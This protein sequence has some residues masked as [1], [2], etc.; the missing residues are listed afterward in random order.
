MEGEINS[1]IKVWFS[2]FISLGY[3]YAISKVVSKG[4]T[5]LICVLSIICLFIFLPVNLHSIHLGGITA[6]FIC[7]LANFKLLL[8]AFGKGPLCSGSSISLGR[9][10]AVGCSP[11][12]QNIPSKSLEKPTINST[13]NI[14]NPSPKLMSHLNGHNKEKTT[15]KKYRVG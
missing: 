4:P 12:Q 15:S 2:V 9:F 3:C 1:F 6:F 14:T 10:V 11:I 13:P 8:F 7:W 5:R